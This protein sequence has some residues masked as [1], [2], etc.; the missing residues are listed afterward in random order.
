MRNQKVGFDY[1]PSKV[2]C[3]V[4]TTLDVIGGKWKGIIL[5]HLIDGKKRFNEFRKLYPAITQ[6]MLTLQ[7]RELEKD[8]IV[9]RE[10]YKEIP[11]K[12]EYSLTEFGRS[13]E[14]IILLMKDWGETHKNRIIN[15]RAIEKEEI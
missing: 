6:R 1:S 4:E 2:G 12:V 3:P 9:H 14:P 13:L 10:I 15:A 8:G 5:Y 11:P 7:L